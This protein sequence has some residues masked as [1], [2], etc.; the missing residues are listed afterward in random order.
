MSR[1]RSP[2][3]DLRL[4]IESLPV[5]TRRATLED[6]SEKS[7][8]ACG[9]LDPTAAMAGHRAP[10]RPDPPQR[11]PRRRLRWLRPRRRSSEDEPALRRLEAELDALRDRA[12]RC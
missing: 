10:T 12:P 1:G 8:L 4:A 5:P 7:L 2:I 3:D 11:S 9:P 6:Q